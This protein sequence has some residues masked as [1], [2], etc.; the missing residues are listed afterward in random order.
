MICYAG[1]ICEQNLMLC[2]EFDHLLCTVHSISA[3]SN[4]VKPFG[5][6]FHNFEDPHQAVVR[7]SSGSCQAVIRQSSSSCQSSSFW[8]L[9]V[10]SRDLS[11]A[12]KETTACKAEKI[13]KKIT[14]LTQNVFLFQLK[15]NHVIQQPFKTCI[16]TLR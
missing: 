10:G 6:A 9:G 5:G 3:N 13:H 8:L 12:K 4:G 2:Y 11:Q 16:H 7:L 15:I 14:I 1:I